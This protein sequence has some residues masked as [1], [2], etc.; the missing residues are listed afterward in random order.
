MPEIVILTLARYIFMPRGYINGAI[1]LFGGHTIPW[2]SPGSPFAMFTVML[3]DAWHV[4]PIVMLMLL[5]GLQTIPQ[6]LYEAARLDGARSL[7]TFRYVTLPLLAPAMVGALA[8]RGIDALR[9][10]STV[11]ILTGPEGV[12]VLST[13]AYGLWSD[14]QQ[15]NRAMAAAVI[16]AVLVMVLGLGGIAILRRWS[17]ESEVVSGER[18]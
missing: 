17:L 6:E 13:Y 14:S 18:A 10:F 5:A 16:L 15:Q 1:A 12:P 7:Q 3:V 2:L 8:L 9:I 4:T 11:L